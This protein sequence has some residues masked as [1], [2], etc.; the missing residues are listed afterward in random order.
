MQ[1]RSYEPE[2]PFGPSM[3]QLALPSLTPVTK[4][5]LIGLSAVFLLVFLVGLAR[6]GSERAIL[7]TCGLDALAWRGWPPVWQLATYGFLHDPDSLGHLAGNLLVLYFFGTMLEGLLGSRRFLVLYGGAQLAG[8]AAFLLVSWLSGSA[9]LAFGAS[10]AAYGVMIAA[11]TLRP[12]QTVLL[13][14]IPITLRW[15]AVGIVTLT[16]FG[17]LKELRTPGPGV[18]HDVHLGGILF[19]FLAVRT[20]LIWRDPLR[21]LEARRAIAREERRASDEQRMDRIL[22]KIHRE[23]MSALDRSERAFLKRAARRRT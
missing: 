2:P 11:A 9:R 10:G 4:R 20:G 13:L 1:N 22:A 21:V 3:P 16:V 7:E 8:A 15:L 14:F 6:P 5:L 12:R 18:A 23:G 17:M 19:G